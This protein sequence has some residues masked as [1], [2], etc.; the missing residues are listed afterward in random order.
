[1]GKEAPCQALRQVPNGI[2]PKTFA[3]DSLKS[4]QRLYPKMSSGVTL[5]LVR[6]LTLVLAL[7]LAPAIAI[8]PATAPACLPRAVLKA[9]IFCS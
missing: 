3:L 9:N 2:F 7:T 6:A 1:M 4:W 5:A 8:A